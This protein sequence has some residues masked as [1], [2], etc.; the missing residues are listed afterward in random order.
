LS[1]R[2]APRSRSR[3]LHRIASASDT[4]QPSRLTRN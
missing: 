4:R 1:S 2:A 3:S